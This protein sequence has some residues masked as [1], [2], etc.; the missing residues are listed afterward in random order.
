MV[1][2][3]IERSGPAMAFSVEVM[4]HRHL[5]LVALLRRDDYDSSS[6]MLIHN[7]QNT[8]RLRIVLHHATT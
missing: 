8:F 3:L 4:V 6:Y 2:D 5:D 7:N 1:V